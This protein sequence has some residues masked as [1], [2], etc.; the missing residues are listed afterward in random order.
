MQIYKKQQTA[1]NM[2]M[3]AAYDIQTAYINSALYAEAVEAE[4]ESAQDKAISF[5]LQ[6]ESVLSVRVFELD[7]NIIVATL[8]SP[9]YLK[10]ERDAARQQLENDLKALL[11]SDKIIVT[12]DVH[13][14]RKIRDGLSDEEKQDLYQ[15]AYERR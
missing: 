4:G 6:N 12:F 15:L 10:S 1:N 3:T 13:V 8:T 2:D 5:A 14:Y 7:G 11:D 9:F